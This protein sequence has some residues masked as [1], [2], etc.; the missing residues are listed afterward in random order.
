MNLCHS[1]GHAHIDQILRSVIGICEETAPNF[2]L[3]YYLTG[4]Y[5]Y[6]EPVPTSDVDLLLINNTQPDEQSEKEQFGSPIFRQYLPPEGE[7]KIRKI[8]TH[9]RPLLPVRVSISYRRE[10]DEKKTRFNPSLRIHR[11]LLFGTDIYQDLFD[12]NEPEISDRGIRLRIHRA[13]RILCDIH[14]VNK[15]LELPLEF[16]DSNDEFF[17]YALEGVAVWGQ[18]LVRLDRF[19]SFV[20][21][22][23]TAL[24]TKKT[25]LNIYRKDTLPNIY[26]KHIGDQWSDFVADTFDLCRKAWQYQIPEDINERKRLREICKN[27]LGFADRFLSFYRDFLLEELASGEPERV[28]M[29]A[30][31]MGQKRLKDL[32]VTAAL[33]EHKDS[34]DD[35]IKQAVS[36]I[37]MS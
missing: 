14:N 18:P 30:M 16:P 9:V 20:Y 25:G 7:K 36:S 24:L 23:C 17:G 22:L 28:L 10:A 8:F 19:V 33:K 34:S 15:E 13:Y 31:M 37:F 35:E 27:A 6:G 21:P 11:V 4:S 12:P 2:V 29:A 1:T 3:S 32:Q 5:A 26:Q